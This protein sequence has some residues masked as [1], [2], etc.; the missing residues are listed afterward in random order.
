MPSKS[1]RE[2]TVMAHA[3]SNGIRIHYETEGKG[4]PLV[5]QHGFSDQLETWYDHGYVES[6][7]TDYTLIL[8]DARGHGGSDKPH[9]PA[10]YDLRLRVGDVTAVLDDLGI[11]KAHY[12]G[13]SMGGG[14][15]FGIAK[16]AAERVHSLILGGMHPYTRDRASGNRRIQT[17]KNGAMES[18]VAAAESQSGPMDTQRKARLLTNDPEALIAAT[19]AI[20]DAPSLEDVL[21]SMMMPC[22]VFT[23]EADGYYASA[24]KCIKSMPTATFFSLPGLNHG[25][26]FERSDL[27]LPHVT[28]FLQEVNGTT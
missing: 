14:I 8:V 21:P 17:L 28:K 5:L 20:Y 26:A 11:S 9:D 2:I 6:L 1:L 16:Y 10:S 23:G 15:G 25:E 27:V 13:Y 18:M 4:P 7:K 22:L 12:F 24:Q 19:Q 3:N